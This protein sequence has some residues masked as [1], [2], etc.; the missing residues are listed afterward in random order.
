[1]EEQ[2]VLYKGKAYRQLYSGL[3]KWGRRAHLEFLDRSQD[4]WVDASRV[5]KRYSL[6]DPTYECDECCE[7][8]KPGTRCP[9]D[10]T[11]H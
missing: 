6:D 3:T 11:T 4:F 5:K 9:S 2:F 8:V 1:M 7:W 10:W